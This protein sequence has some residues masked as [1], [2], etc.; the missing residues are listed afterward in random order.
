MSE[1][2]HIEYKQSW[3]DEYLKWISGFANAEGGV[4]AIGRDDDGKVVGLKDGKKLL[5]DI[6]N[7][8][9]D[10]LGILVIV[11]LRS[12][13]QLE[14]LE[15]MVEPYPNPISHKGKYY[16]RSGSTLQELNGAALDRFILRAQGKT[17]DGV[18]VPNVGLIDL[19]PESFQHFRKKATRSKR[20]A[21]DILR[22]PDIVLLDKLRLIEG[23]YLKRAATLLFHPDPERF[24]T[25]AFVKIGYFHSDT[26]LAY[27]DEIHGDLFTQV[28]KTLDLLLTKYTKALISY[29][30][31]QRVETY[32]VPEDALREAVTNAIVHKDYSRGAP[33]QISVYADKLMIW[34]PGQLPEDWTVERL[35]QKHSSE[36]FNPE[37]A[38]VFFRAGMIESWGRGIERIFEA[39]EKAACPKPK[40]RY[41]TTGLWMEFPIKQQ[42]QSTDSIGAVTAQET[43]Q[44]TTQEKIL[45]LLRDQPT[46][47]RKALAHK[48]KLSDSGVKYHLDKLRN[49]EIIKHVGPT[50]GGHWEVLK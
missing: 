13:G 36:P 4:L 39:C 9:R 15:I 34:N 30:G 41:E 12:E 5:E 47:T 18:P 32:S 21:D 40:L 26:D 16:L 38:N 48:L 27:Q 43:T 45:G 1:S 37:I 24:V 11:N 8:V 46:I 10:L 23:D 28:D 19:S 31:A 42:R 35:L 3:R 20:L 6:P 25:A 29:E 50:K 49:S 7:K 17:W 22:E 33:I 2:Q 44:E 14:Y